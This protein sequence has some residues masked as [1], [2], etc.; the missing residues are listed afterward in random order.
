MQ[1]TLHAQTNSTAYAY[2]DSL[3]STKTN[4]LFVDNNSALTADAITEET[5]DQQLFNDLNVSLNKR[6]DCARISL[7]E[8]E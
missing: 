7:V 3:K 2:L 5:K 4:T 6:T 8:S 1:L